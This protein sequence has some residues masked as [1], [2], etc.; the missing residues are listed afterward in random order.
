MA[1]WVVAI[2]VLGFASAALVAFVILSRIACYEI[3][4]PKRLI[5]E[6]LAAIAIVGGLYLLMAKVLLIRMPSGLLF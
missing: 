3:M 4:G 5:I 2:P 6:A 1:L